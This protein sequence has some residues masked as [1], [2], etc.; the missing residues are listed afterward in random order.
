MRK[1]TN[2][3]TF[4]IMLSNLKL[5]KAKRT[6]ISTPIAWFEAPFLFRL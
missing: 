5:T 6:L 2:R 1:G 3:T 4:K